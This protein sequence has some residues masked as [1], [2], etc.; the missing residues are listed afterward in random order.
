MLT[1]EQCRAARGLLG[2]TQQDLANAAGLSKTA[3]NNFERGTTDIKGESM[4]A[5]R[6][7]FESADIAFVGDYGV[8]KLTDT[9]QLLKGENA[10]KE[11]W[12]DIF[13]TMMQT[14]GEILIS[15]VDEKRTE[16]MEKKALHN[17][18]NRLKEHNITERLLCCEGDTYFLMPVECYRWISKETFTYGT[19]TYIYNNKIA[20]QLWNDSIIVIINSKDAATAE[21]Q[22]FEYLWKNAKIPNK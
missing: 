2:W 11:L 7:A 12:D 1:R 18:L 3:I 8:H 13:E 17:H 19:S 15:N 6:K 9:V 4:D 16:D 21:R 10:L 14:G 22:R 20:L 5:I